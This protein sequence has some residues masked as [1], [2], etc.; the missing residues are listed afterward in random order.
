MAELVREKGKGGVQEISLSAEEMAEKV[1]KV[2]LK[3]LKAWSEIIPPASGSGS[4]ARYLIRSRDELKLLR[5]RAALLKT[6]MS[7][8]AVK[9]VEKAGLLDAYAS[10]AVDCPRGITAHIWR[11]YG[12]VVLIQMRY[13]KMI[14]P[15]ELAQRA[16][17]LEKKGRKNVPDVAM[18]ER[19]LRLLQGL[20][21]LREVSGRW[22]HKGLPEAWTGSH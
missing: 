22:E 18:A 16:G 10:L 15:A 6:N 2:E 8:A 17:M 11:S 14:G 12:V 21:Y 20:G 7:P 19:H 5:K 4:E 9:E 13:G 1:L 3:D